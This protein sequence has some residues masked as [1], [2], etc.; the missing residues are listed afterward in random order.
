[1]DLIGLEDYCAELCVGVQ[2]VPEG[3]GLMP[4]AARVEELDH[5]PDLRENKERMEA[6]FDLKTKDPDPAGGL[7][8]RENT[9]SWE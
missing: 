3:F 8:D 1:M 6:L 2:C 5:N 9:G 7:S 4:P